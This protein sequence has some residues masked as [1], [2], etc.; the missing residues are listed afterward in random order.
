M[1]AVPAGHAPLLDVAGLAV[2]FPGAH[3]DVAAVTDAAFSVAAG[4]TLGIVGESGSG[5]TVSAL[6]IMGLV[7]APARVTARTLAIAGHDVAAL[8]PGDRAR[9]AL[10]ARRVAMIFQDPLASLDPCY[11]VGAQLDEVLKE[12]G[13]ADERASRARRRAR[14]LEL[15]RDVEIPDPA[16]RLA[17]YPHQLSGGMAQRVMIALALA[18]RPALLIADE[19]TTA[20]D[21][22]VQAQV[23]ALLR[24]LQAE[25]GMA[26][27]MISHDLAVVAAMAAR[28]VVMYAG[29]VVESGAVPAI[30]ATPRHPYTAAL[31][32]ALPESV[33]LGAPLAALPGRVPDPRHRPAG[34][35]FAPRC[36]RR[37]ERC[38]ETR[39]ALADAG[40]T[41]VR[42]FFP[43]HGPASPAVAGAMP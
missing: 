32:A 10:L 38:T 12:A 13:T 30:F 16:A 33:P 35:V 31:V 43:L 42:C 40:G 1:D 20:L 11:S 8:R 3:G 15:L 19:P 25:T 23:L 5:K 27:L 26:L 36:A 24:K 18:A 29:E 6:A 39:P 4:E 28:V 17:A 9:R 21:V 34:C 7:D 14:A 37:A 22:T 2:S 41:A